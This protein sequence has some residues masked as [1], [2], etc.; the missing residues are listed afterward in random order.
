ARERGQPFTAVILRRMLALW[1]FGMAHLV[2]FWGGDILHDYAFGGLLLLG[3][4]WLLD[5]RPMQR[6]NNPDSILRFSLIF[7][8]FPFI[9]MTLAGTIYLLSH[10]TTKL[11]ASWEEK[12]LLVEQS[13]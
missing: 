12:Q 11:R 9:M 5:R 8:A 4:I 13:D 1:L 10:D 3:W 2:F 6:F 7:M